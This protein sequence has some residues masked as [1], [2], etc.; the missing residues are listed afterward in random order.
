VPTPAEKGD[1][2]QQAA[3][4]IEEHILRTSPALREKTLLI[5]DKKVVCVGGVHHEIDIF[6]TVNVAPGYR[7][8]YIFEC[9]NW[10][11]AIGKKE[12]V[13]FS[14]KI[15]AVNAAHGYFIAKS[16]TKDARAQARK[17]ARVTVLVATERD[18]TNVPIPGE[19]HLTLITPKLLEVNAFKRIR[20]GDDLKPVEVQKAELHGAE[21][22]FRDYLNKW[23]DAVMSQDSLLIPSHRMAPGDHDRTATSK[24]Q[25]EPGQFLLNGDDIEHLA[26]DMKYVFSIYKPPLISYFDIESRGRVLALAPVTAQGGTFQMRII[27]RPKQ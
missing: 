25:F 20:S 24:R 4:A 26:M 23:A 15:D 22:N 16:F 10:K 17:D 11:K 18:P 5:E 8:I 3:H 6:V 27:E 1:A 7:A 9:K 13:D 12:I 21:I 14:E 2:L 19:L